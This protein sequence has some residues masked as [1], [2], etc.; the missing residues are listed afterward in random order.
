MM[1]V[2]ICVMSVHCCWSFGKVSEVIVAVALEG[3]TED[4]HSRACCTIEA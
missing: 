3:R 2:L 4:Q 1:M